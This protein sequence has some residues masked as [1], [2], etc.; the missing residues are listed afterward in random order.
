[1]LARIGTESRDVANKVGTAS[2]DQQANEESLAEAHMPPFLLTASR[3][4]ALVGIEMVRHGIEE[5]GLWR[6][7]ITFYAKSFET[8]GRKWSLSGE[9]LEVVRR[10]ER[11]L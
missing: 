10:E 4:M 6:K 8:V 3:D 7:V 5:G 1:M 2:G 9:Y 11:G